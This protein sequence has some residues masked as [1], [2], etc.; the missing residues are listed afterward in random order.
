MKY[1]KPTIYKSTNLSLCFN[2]IN[3]RLGVRVYL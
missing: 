2:I 3:L 1:K